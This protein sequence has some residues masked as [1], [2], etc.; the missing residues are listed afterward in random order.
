MSVTWPGFV[1]PSPGLIQLPL[2][3]STN[4]PAPYDESLGRVLQYLDSI[5]RYL[6]TYPN[7]SLGSTASSIRVNDVIEPRWTEPDTESDS[8]TS[9][10][11]LGLRM[12]CLVC[13]L[14]EGEK[15]GNSWCDHDTS[16]ALSVDSYV[17]SDDGVRP[18]GA[19]VQ[20]QVPMLGV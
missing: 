19:D 20:M 6:K 1:F 16:D 18:G 4:G 15:L 3:E 7:E 14:T 11:V 8:R 5:V 2:P 12:C 13:R 9:Q 10:W 17:G